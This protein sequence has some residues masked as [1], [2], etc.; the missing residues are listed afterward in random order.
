MTLSVSSAGVTIETSDEIYDLMEAEAKS[1]SAKS[2]AAPKAP[3]PPAATKPAV[4][5]KATPPAPP[6]VATNGKWRIQLGAFSK[7][8]SAEALLSVINDILDFSKIEAG[9]LELEHVEFDLPGLVEGVID[10]FANRAAEKG[11][12]L[13]C[14]LS[15]KT[16][17]LVA[18]DPERVRQLLVNLV[19]N[20]LRYT[21]DGGV[22]VGVRHQQ[23]RAIRVDVWD[24]GHGIAPEHQQRVFE[25]FGDVTDRKTI[26]LLKEI[27]PGFP[28]L[29]GDFDRLQQLFI[30]LVDNAIKY[31]PARGTVTFRA[32]LL[33]ENP[34]AELWRAADRWSARGEGAQ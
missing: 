20:A 25:V 15:P 26:R 23:D 27:Q 8:S 34:R 2:T 31:T 10:M 18:G 32:G 14:R 33:P 24:T 3:P 29:L 4:A 21:D 22:L 13:V 16:P 17:R 7:K 19:S 6:P 11:L 1:P 28:P 9:K 30:N 12:E 5:A